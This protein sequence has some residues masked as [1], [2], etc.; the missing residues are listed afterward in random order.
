VADVLR[1]DW[2]FYS[3]DTR[4]HPPQQQTRNKFYSYDDIEDTT[5]AAKRKQ[6]LVHSNLFLKEVEACMHS[7]TPSPT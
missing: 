7:A 6:V 2:D 1:F 3:N 5:T 4:H